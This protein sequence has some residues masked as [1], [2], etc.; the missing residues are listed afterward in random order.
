MSP[1]QETPDFFRPQFVCQRLI[2]F[3]PPLVFACSDPVYRLEPIS[4][5]L[6]DPAWRGLRLRQTCWL[7]WSRIPDEARRVVSEVCLRHS[8][9]D[10]RLRKL[11][12][13]DGPDLEGLVDLRRRFEE[14]VH[15]YTPWLDPNMT[16]C[17]RETQPG[18]HMPR[19]AVVTDLSSSRDQSRH[20]WD[21][22]E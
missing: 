9:W 6:G 3:S 17:L 5:K 14:G 19:L 10:P 21:L 11:A 12:P 1:H 2:T 7:R 8:R 15:D 4:E 13:S 22:C 16:T 18:L 20:V